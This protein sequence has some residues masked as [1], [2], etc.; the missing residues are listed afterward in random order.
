MNWLD[1]V[2][3]PQIKQTDPQRRKVMPEGLWLKC[4]ACETVLYRNDFEAN[5]HV[6]PK[7]SHHMPIGARERLDHLLDAEGRRE[8]G[9]EILPVDPLKFKDKRP[10]PDRLSEALENT[11][12]TDA[13]VVMS[14]SMH[15][16]PVVAAC[17][18]FSFMAGSM[19]SAV[20][21]RFVRGVREA[22]EQRAPFICISASGGARMQ[23]SVYSLMQMAKTTAILTR[24]AD[25]RLPFISVLTD[26]TTG[27]VSASF[28]FLGDVVLAEPK[29]LIAFTGERV[30]EQTV[31]E[32]LPEGYQRPEFL[33]ER[34]AIDMIVDRREMR[35][36]IARLIALLM[37]QPADN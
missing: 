37:L 25:A 20:G 15:S 13:L 24:L 26:P 4:P 6:C 17:F 28:A 29:A 32:T 1:K 21:E 33:L 23:E 22:L 12:E 9:R 27:G 19:G 11:G 16:I 7:C 8:I 2:L 10:Y 3:P 36:E 31:R 30:I 35:T 34:G 18:D 5:L 14:G